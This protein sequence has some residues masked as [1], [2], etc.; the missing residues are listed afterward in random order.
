MVSI[1]EV[2]SRLSRL[3]LSTSHS[4]MPSP[5]ESAVHETREVDDFNWAKYRLQRGFIDIDGSLNLT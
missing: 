5:I 4:H 3:R 2:P 1:S